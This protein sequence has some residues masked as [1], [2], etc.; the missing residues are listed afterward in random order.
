[1]CGPSSERLVRHRTQPV[2]GF[3]LEVLSPQ[4]PPFPQPLAPEDS[5]SY[6][7]DSALSI[8]SYELTYFYTALCIYLAALTAFLG[9]WARFP[10]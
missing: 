8:R 10:R 3:R 2:A 4:L 5:K 7:W 6:G 1:M 9:W